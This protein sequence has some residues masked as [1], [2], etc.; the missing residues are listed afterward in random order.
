MS[1]LRFKPLTP[2]TWPDFRSLFGPK[3]ACA[4]CWCMYFVQ[5]QGEFESRKGEKNRRA[6]KRRVDAGEVP[7]ILAYDGDEAI[8]WCAVAPRERFTRLARSKVVAPVDDKPV[9]SVPCFFVHRDCRGQGVSVALLNAA[10][11]QVRRKRG[12]IVEGY[13]VDPGSR[14]YPATFAYYGLVATFR[15]AGFKEVARRSKT[16]PVMRRNLRG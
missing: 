11:E 7:G 8:G 3:G 13:P 6:M 2:K 15:K 16:R 1:K 5:T 4:G 10:A 9:W 12:K 14:R